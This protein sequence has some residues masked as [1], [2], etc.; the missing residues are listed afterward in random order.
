M[1]KLRHVAIQ[2]DDP[3]TTAKFYCAVMEMKEM[4]RIGLEKSD[5]EG[6]IYLSD[7]V[8]NLALIRILRPDFPN[9]LPRGLNHIGFVVE[10]LDEAVAF[11]EKHGFAYVVEEPQELKFRPKSY[12]DN[13]RYDRVG[14]WTH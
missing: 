1:A 2:C 13:F 3:D 14:R 9:Y 10:N 5:S 11:A 8:V 12:A 6:A 7:G 4:Y